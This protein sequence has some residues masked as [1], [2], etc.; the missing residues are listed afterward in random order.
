MQSADEIEAAK[1]CVKT[2]GSLHFEIRSGHQR[3]QLSGAIR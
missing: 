3:S 2:K 1:S